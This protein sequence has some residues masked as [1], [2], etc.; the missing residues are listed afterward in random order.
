M[1]SADARELGPQPV[2]EVLDLNGDVRNLILGESMRKYARHLPVAQV[3][4]QA[5][6]E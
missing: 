3:G 1:G 4:T 2:E 5:R 6:V